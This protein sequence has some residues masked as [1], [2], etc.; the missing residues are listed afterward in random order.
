M[1][2][3]EMKFKRRKLELC[4]RMAATPCATG[5]T[6]PALDHIFSVAF[7]MTFEICIIREGES[8]WAVLPRTTL[9]CPCLHSTIE[10]LSFSLRSLEMTGALVRKVAAVGLGSNL[11]R[12]KHKIIACLVL[13]L[14]VEFGMEFNQHCWG[15]GL[16]LKIEWPAAQSTP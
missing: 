10:I 3:L 14:R 15:V 13:L 12:P 11:A 9:R 1:H 8:C 6:K 2:V 7:K 16:T 4:F 5:V